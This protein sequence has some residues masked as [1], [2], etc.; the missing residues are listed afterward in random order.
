M[1]AY[2]SLS[3][4]LSNNN[5]ALY[6]FKACFIRQDKCPFN[7]DGQ[8]VKPNNENDFVNL[9]DL[10][11]SSKIFDFAGIGISIQASDISAI[12]VDKCF[13][14]PFD[15]NSGDDRAKDIINRFKDLAYI[16]FSFS[17]K[18]LRI[19]FHTKNIND[20]CSKYYIKNEKVGC[21]FYQ[22]SN[23][24]RFVTLTGRTI[25]NNSLDDKQDLYETL[26]DFLNKYMQRPK[27][28]PR[29]SETEQKQETRSFEELNKLLEYHLIKN[30][31]FQDDWFSTPSGY[32][33]NE[34]ETDFRIL[35]YIYDHITRDYD[36]M[37]QL[38]ESSYYFKHK[39]RAHIYKWQRQDYR[40][41]N[42][43]YNRL[44]YKI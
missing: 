39:D 10:A 33:G 14:I 24:A 25:C 20:Y 23:S 29:L 36:K 30:F 22:P 44:S 1:D 43:I 37:K 9:S 13:S 17:G 2:D 27:I 40:Y 35:L 8:I 6:N 11:T 31:Y 26:I 38:F 21:E 42:Y 19:L 15:I 28:R 32:G 41:Y 5:L 12:D 34:S 3:N 18:G 7:K 16:E 4:I